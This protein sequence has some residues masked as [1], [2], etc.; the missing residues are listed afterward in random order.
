MLTFDEPGFENLQLEVFRDRIEV[1]WFNDR[2][3][4]VWDEMRTPGEGF[5][6]AFIRELP[7]ASV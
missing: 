2:L 1:Y 3:F 4:D 5:S 6:E 7:L